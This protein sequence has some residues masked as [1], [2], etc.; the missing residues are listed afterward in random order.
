MDSKDVS[1]ILEVV[2]K[3]QGVSLDEIRGE[4]ELALRQAQENSD[5]EMQAQWAKIPRAGE[6]PTPEE[7]ILYLS[8]KLFY[9]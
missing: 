5:M 7:V 8:E 1:R 3:E 4:I 2:A 9:E 6:K